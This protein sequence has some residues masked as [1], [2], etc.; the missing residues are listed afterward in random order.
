MGPRRELHLVGQRREA[1]RGEA[2]SQSRVERLDLSDGQDPLADAPV[3]PQDAHQPR[4][5]Q[6]VAGG[7][8]PVGLSGGVSSS[9]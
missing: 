4:L 7:P 1:R 3:R 9:T 6:E 8:G 2:R 5:Q